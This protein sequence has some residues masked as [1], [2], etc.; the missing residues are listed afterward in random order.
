MRK[1][2]WTAF[3]LVMLYLR[4]LRDLRLLI[5]ISYNVSYRN[6]KQKKQK[7]VRIITGSGEVIPY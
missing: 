2:H 3:E 4:D 1:Y 6:I 7:K 5:G